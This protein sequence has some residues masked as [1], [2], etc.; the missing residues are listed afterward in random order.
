[1]EPA[2]VVDSQPLPPGRLVVVNQ[3]DHTVSVVDLATKQVLGKV[4]VGVNGHEVACSQDGRFAFVPI[5]SNVGVGQE[6]TDGNQIDVVD[7]HTFEVARSIDLGK[8]VRP[9][10]VQLGSDGLLYVSAEL[11]QSLYAVDVTTDRVVAKTFTSAPES[12][13]FVMSHDAKKAYTANIGPGSVSVLDLKTRELEAII[14]VSNC[15]QRISMSVDGRHVFTHDQ[16]K[17]QI[18]VIDTQTDTVTDWISLPGTAFCSA[19][20]PDG[21]SLIVLANGIHQILVVDLHSRKITRSFAIPPSTIGL[22]V[23][24]T[25]NFAFVSCI[26]SGQ[27]AILNLQ[28]W[29][30]EAPIQ[31]EIG[32]DGLAWLPALES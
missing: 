9:H 7:L 22:F 24:P 32:V 2:S 17:P 12:H 20:T 26:G 30:M 28:T 8:P 27:I 6:G 18:A 23:D 15:I 5:Y 4:S 16:S 21:E 10:C 14:D 31:L 3:V 19:P 1:M 25:G 13:M 11:D 29:T